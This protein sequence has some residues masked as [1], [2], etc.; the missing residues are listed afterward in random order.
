ME[1]K[2]RTRSSKLE[3]VVESILQ[4]KYPLLQKSSKVVTDQIEYN[5][6]IQEGSH[7]IVDTSVE[8]LDS[9]AISRDL[10]LV[11]KSVTSEIKR[12]KTIRTY[13]IR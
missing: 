9:H 4:N 3:R 11:I 8:C 1:N 2:F 6:A 10:K 7:H 13:I 5:S 12:L